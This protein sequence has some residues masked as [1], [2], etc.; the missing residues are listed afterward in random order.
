MS[1]DVTQWCCEGVF[2]LVMRTQQH[3]PVDHTT[4]S[5]SIMGMKT[6]RGRHTSTLAD[7]LQGVCWMFYP[8]DNSAPVDNSDQEYNVDWEQIERSYQVDLLAAGTR[9]FCS[10]FGI[11]QPSPQSSR[12]RDRGIARIVTQRQDLCER[13]TKLTSDTSAPMAYPAQPEMMEAAG[14]RFPQPVSGDLSTLSRGSA[15]PRHSVL[16]TARSSRDQAPGMF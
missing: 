6:H 5:C 1:P 13:R 16:A 15:S 3:S 2:L 10:C 11:A 12:M 4:E 7:R 9:P 8:A 14:S